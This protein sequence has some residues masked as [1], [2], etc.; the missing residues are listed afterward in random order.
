MVVVVVVVVVARRGIVDVADQG[1]PAKAFSGWK[2]IIHM[3]SPRAWSVYACAGVCL[4][5]KNTTGEKR[6]LG[7]GQSRRG[8]RA[9]KE[10]IGG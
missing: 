6:Y 2:G 5:L 8:Y 1:R 4:C 7:F 3:H 9:P 10:G